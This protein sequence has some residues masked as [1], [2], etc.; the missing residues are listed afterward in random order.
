MKR[1]IAIILVIASLGVTILSGGCSIVTRGSEYCYRF[2]DYIC[3][4]TFDKA[5]EMLADNIK[6]PET[7]DER[8]DRLAEEAAEKEEN[9]KIW[10]E[11]FGL[12]KAEET[13]PAEDVTP[14]PEDGTPTPEA[15]TTPAPEGA[16]INGM[17][18]DPE[19]GEYPVIEATPEPTES[20]ESTPETDLPNEDELPAD[21]RDDAETPAPE[22]STEPA[23]DTATPVP[24][25]SAEPTD[26]T[27]DE[28]EATL[29][30]DATPTPTPDPDATA[31]PAPSEEDAEEEIETTV[32]KVGFIEKYQNIYDE[33]ELTSIDYNVTEVLDGEI[34]ARVTYDLTYHSERAGEDLTYSFTIEANRIEHRWTIDWSPSLIFPEMEWGDSLRVGVLQANRG[35]I[36]CN[37]EAYA[38]NVNTITVFCVPSTI[39]DEE[40]FIRAVANVPEMEMTEDDV[41]KALTNQRND[42]CK[43]KTF[44]PDE[45]TMDLKTRLLAIEGIAIDT[46]NYG[47]LRYYPYGDSLCHII[48]YAGIISKKE[49]INYETYGDVRY[50]EEN[51]RFYTTDTRYNG[52]S[53]I[54]KYGLEQLYEDELL[55]T[56][57]R[58]TYIQTAEGGSRGM[59]YS[60]NA[61]DGY[62][63]H[64]TI[65][66][67]LQ[68]RLEDVV[69]TTV[70]DDSIHGC[71][72][73][74]NP[75][76]GEIQAMTSWP[77]F[78]LNDLSRG[79]PLEEWE[80]MQN[81]SV[82]IPL[83]NRATQ[84]LYTP[85]S[86]FKLLT[87][88]ALL[89]T[90]TMTINDVF[91][92]SEE[93]VQQDKW[94]PSETFLNNL[95][96]RASADTWYDQ[97]QDHFLVRT[98]SDSR[99]SPMN[100][101]NSVLSSDN[102][103]FSY[104]AMR[105]GWTKFSTF[106]DSIGWNTA[107][108]LEAQGTN[109]RIYWQVNEA[110]EEQISWLNLAEGGETIWKQDAEGNWSEVDGVHLVLDKM[111]YGLDISQPQ[112]HNERSEAL[113]LTDYDLAVTGYGQGEI[114]M[115]PLQMACYASAYANDGVIMQPYLVD[116]IWHA[117]GTNYTLIEQRTPQVYR[118]AFQQSTVDLLYPALLKVCERTGTARWLARSFI[119]RGPLTLGYTMAGKTGTAELDNDKTK[120]LAWFICWRDNLDGEPVT[121]EDARL[122]CIMLEVSL[123]LGDEW[124]QMK[125][126]I[127]RAMLKED[128]LNDTEG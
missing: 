27:S 29:D 108:Q 17:T 26:D 100:M 70:Y 99:P 21:Q 78:D 54:G 102:L 81:D 49:K 15:E 125:M 122:V 5:Y 88:A 113:P 94:F 63:L 44:Y 24:E 61:V 120:E 110:D 31:T 73:V 16:M 104:A 64:L 111:L 55:G 11:V 116:S 14:T 127:A 37:G 12:D 33:L 91:P 36:L 123:P 53:Y 86:V 32:T 68:E 2:L 109:P 22:D 80:A 28:A 38:Q 105:M 95:Q 98:H 97:S 72:I 82:N 57:G 115:S 67:E 3:E 23:D 93:I 1:F 106:M 85:G 20:A 79:L 46:A 62:D 52:D 45:A 58:F 9:R 4:G 35:E 39:P 75:K 84:G 47:T 124:S 76:T 118:Q 66:P 8:Q 18:P 121:E 103:F 40:D 13:A 10:R 69:D 56:N 77:G 43:L 51:D 119:T 107:I 117:D 71:V 41:R 48:G 87:S 128:T 25:D 126:D 34:F 60:T 89:E 90:N 50:D 74:I 42:F 19:T 6:A 96:E 83:F 30:P 101:T 7:E 114:L 112:L 65:I 59:L 92:A